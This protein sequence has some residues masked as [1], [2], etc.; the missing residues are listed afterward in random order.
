M[1]ARHPEAPLQ[2]FSTRASV[3]A[4]KNS[5]RSR[6]TATSCMCA[7]VGPTGKKGIVAVTRAIA[8]KSALH[9]LAG[10]A[11][12]LVDGGLIGKIRRTSP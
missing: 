1:E 2:A 11:E 12:H 6:S 3:S 10:L 9:P 5:K 7:P 8:P 4:I